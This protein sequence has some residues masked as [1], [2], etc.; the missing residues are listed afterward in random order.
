MWLARTWDSSEKRAAS[1]GAA[2][3]TASKSKK[4]G[5]D[6]NLGDDRREVQRSVKMVGC[7]EPRPF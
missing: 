7:G 3:G 4:V 6:G 2:A 5:S 1:G